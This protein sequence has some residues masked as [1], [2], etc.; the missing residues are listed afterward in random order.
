MSIPDA[1]RATYIRSFPLPTEKDDIVAILSLAVPLTM[2]HEQ[3]GNL[4]TADLILDSLGLLADEQR[5]KLRIEASAWAAKVD[6][7]LQNAMV[8]YS[9]DSSFIQVLNQF[10][11]KLERQSRRKK[12]KLKS[13]LLLLPPLSL[14]VIVIANP[15]VFLALP[16]SLVIFNEPLGEILR[17]LF[18][19]VRPVITVAF[20]V[21]LA[22]LGYQVATRNK[23]RTASDPK[24]S[25]QT[26][27]AGTTV[28]SKVST[29]TSSMSSQDTQQYLQSN[30]SK[31]VA[32]FLCFFLGFLGIHRFYVGKIGTGLLMFF[33]Y[34]GFGLMWLFDIVMLVTSNFK[35]KRGYRIA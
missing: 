16:K 4:S 28:L 19:N 5:E 2:V 3:H 34:G 24:Q 27:N 15:S 22:W 1:Q 31:S 13:L 25:Y 23:K 20:L 29:T 30:K 17:N 18:E 14:V 35:D 10:Q 9:R 26:D 11:E 8:L 6:A 21:F 32:L 12:E 7:I 33:T